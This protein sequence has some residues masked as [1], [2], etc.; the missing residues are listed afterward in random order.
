MALSKSDLSTALK[1]AFI[2]VSPKTGNKDFD[3]NVATQQEKLAS[4]MASAIEK[5]L[6]S[7]SISITLPTPLTGAV[8]GTAASIPGPIVG[9][10]SANTSDSSSSS[11]K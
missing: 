6:T 8:S 11:T 1:N 5:Y 4:D 10:I 7:G 2:A 3:D 9:T